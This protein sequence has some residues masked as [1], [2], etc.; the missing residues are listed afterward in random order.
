MPYHASV[1]Y[2]NEDDTAFDE[3]YYMQTH[4]PLVEKTWSKHGLISWKVV[5]YSSSLDGSKSQFLI[6][7]LLE[8]ESEEAA[9]NALKDPESATIFGDIPNF[10]NKKPIT[11]AGSQL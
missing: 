3:T 5:K 6:A 1:M 7:A 11:I 8:F 4:M 10:T 2:P 9:T